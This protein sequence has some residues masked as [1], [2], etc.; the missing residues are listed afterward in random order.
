[1]LNLRR[2]LT[3][4][5]A[6]G[7]F[8]SASRDAAA[9]VPSDL[10]AGNPC[11]VTG[12][13]TVD[14]GSDLD[15]GAANLVIATN[16]TITIGAGT[17]STATIRAASITMQQNAKIVG[18]GSVV[19]LFT[20]VGNFTMQSAGLQR[21][22]ID[23]QSLVG[24]EINITSAANA[25]IG[26]R[27][28]ADGQ[29]ADSEGGFIIINAAGTFSNTELISAGASG[30]FSFGGEIAI[31]AGT[32]VTVGGL[33]DTS[34]AGS[35]GGFLEINAT[36]GD[37]LVNAQI[38]TSGGDPDG[39]GGP[40][41]IIAAAGSIIT[42]AELRARGGAGP[43]EDC[44]DGGEVN[45]TAG[46]NIQLGAPVTARGGLQCFGGDV[47]LVAGN[48]L[49]QLATAPIDSFGPGA[50][51]GGGS[52]S[53]E[54]ARNAVFDDVDLGST[55]FGGF[56]DVVVLGTA[57]VGGLFTAASTALPDSI[58][59]EINIQACGL[60][61]SATGDVDARGN[62]LFPGFGV[63][64]LKSGAAMLVQGRV[65]AAD[66]VELR[67]KTIPPVVTGTVV[68]AP[69]VIQD[70][71]LPD[72][73]TI[74]ACGDGTVNGSDVCDDNNNV[75]C[76]GCRADC[77]RFDDVCGDGIVEC[78]EQCDGGE[79]CLPDCTFPGVEG[80]RIPGTLRVPAGCLSEWD[81][82]DS[83]PTIDRGGFPLPKQDCIDGDPGCDADQVKDG[84]CEVETRVCA[85]VPDDRLPVCRDSVGPIEFIQIL[86]PKPGVSTETY[87]AQN[88]IAL[89]DAL[90][91][92]G[93]TIRVGDSNI[94]TGPP[95]GGADTCT[96]PFLV[97][98]PISGSGLRFD[99]RI[100]SIAAEDT[101]GTRMGRNRFLVRCFPNPAICGNGAIEVSE[102]CDDSNTTA[103]DGCSASCRVEA[104]GN[105][106]QECTEECDEGPLNGTEGSLC[107][108][109][110]E[111]IIPVPDLRIRGGGS[112][113]TDCAWRWS[114]TLDPAD[115]VVDR[116]GDPK[117]S[118]TCVDGDPTCDIGTDPGR[119]RM[120]VWGCVGEA[121]AAA[122]CSAT[123]VS[124]TTIKSPKATSRHPNEV[125]ANGALAQAIADLGLPKGPAT[126][127]G[128]FCAPFEV[129]IP[130]N[131]KKIVLKVLSTTPG[132]P[133]TDTLKL[134][135][136]AS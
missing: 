96:E 42:T 100:V 30:T 24:G 57:T 39:E 61:V 63:V 130:V 105:G 36:T 58:G 13:K 135:C 59:G 7:L 1:V 98:S 66:R 4:G 6:V 32:G 94:Q 92:L 48:D 33:L 55:G 62:L 12:N 68:P 73:A 128:E 65:R 9:T 121:D 131:R 2:L 104:C 132:K 43:E 47:S 106:V 113:I 79:N 11:T 115:V 22:L 80:V 26:G 49:T 77:T 134:F 44:G 41:D 88:A 25:V 76:D 123:T 52:L 46:T 111:E 95:I 122:Q 3:F 109:T 27:L 127:N 93:T 15:F 114:V 21:S 74:V 10:C 8:A 17:P 87:N 86:K 91:G 40:I 116:K 129:E 125:A 69:L 5:V 97:K 34:A 110:C 28:D 119:C 103:C 112:R 19:N 51:G 83:D 67:H 45:L 117:S 14:S 20:T 108:A 60:T 31:T 64:R 107:T 50:F 75:S 38:L 54:I 99:S 126:E 23:V 101:N 56:A 53:A 84:D 136:K 124:Q 90:L 37:V 89:R 29:G 78:G 35:D 18:S 118:Q 16:A 102:S 82:K 120:R 85:R 72:C 70:P 133:D 81:V 71:S